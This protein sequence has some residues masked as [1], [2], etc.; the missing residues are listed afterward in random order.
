MSAIDVV[1]HKRYV[2]KSA[3][4]IFMAGGCEQN[5]LGLAARDS[6]FYPALVR[7]ERLVGQDLE[8]KLFGV[9]GKRL[10]LVSNRNAYKL[11][12]LDHGCPPEEISVGGSASLEK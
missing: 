11:N 8:S 1:G 9:E 12:C 10:L 2:R 7:V 4:T 6:Q 3:D 5:H